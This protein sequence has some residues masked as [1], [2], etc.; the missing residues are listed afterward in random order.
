MTLKEI[1]Y[2]LNLSPESIILIYV[3][4]HTLVMTSALPFYRYSEA[5]TFWTPILD[6]ASSVLSGLIGCLIAI[7]SSSMAYI[8]VHSINYTE[9]NN[10]PKVVLLLVVSI[11]IALF[12][13]AKISSKWLMFAMGMG[14]GCFPIFVL[15]YKLV[16]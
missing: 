12:M 7:L 4:L 6:V 5:P 10:F 15:F 3:T 9:I 16:Q 8:F 2:Y 1:F 14:I 13:K 11:T